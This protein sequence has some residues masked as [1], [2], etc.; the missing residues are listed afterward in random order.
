MAN[1]PYH[2]G[3]LLRVRDYWIEE[4]DNWIHYRPRDAYVVDFI[5]SDVSSDASMTHCKWGEFDVRLKDK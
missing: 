4:K 5:A 3:Q 1:N 2:T